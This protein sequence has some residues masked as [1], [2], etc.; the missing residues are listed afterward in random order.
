MRTNLFFII[1]VLLGLNIMAQV[2]VNTSNPSVT[3]DI[4]G[5]NDGG[6]VTSKDGIVVPIVNDLTTN[7]SVV[8]QM[9][10]LNQNIGS[11]FIKGF[12]YWSGSEWI[13]ILNVSNTDIGEGLEII[14][15]KLKATG[16]A[17]PK[18]VSAGSLTSDQI[19]TGFNGVFMSDGNFTYNLIMPT[20][21]DF[22]G[23][24]FIIRNNAGFTSTLSA[25][26]T[27]MSASLTLGGY[28]SASPT[29]GEAFIWSGDKWLHLTN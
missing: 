24:I 14:D 1:L 7:G 11:N 12:H 16:E 8:G 27:D 29:P 2:G 13:R 6:A 10:F 28:L 26:N 23:E 17:V 19:P 22:I 4:K 18:L 3:L 20:Q 15:G 9:V 21:R 25:D 5:T